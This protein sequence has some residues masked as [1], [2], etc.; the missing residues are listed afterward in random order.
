MFLKRRLRIK[1]GKPSRG[2]SFRTVAADAKRLRNFPSRVRWERRFVSGF[3]R[4]GDV[5][6]AASRRS[7]RK[8]SGREKRDQ[9]LVTPAATA[10]KIDVVAH[11]THNLLT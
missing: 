1:D 7:G 4:D 11:A 2:R 9:N 3:G 8:R 10:A 6:P 5:K